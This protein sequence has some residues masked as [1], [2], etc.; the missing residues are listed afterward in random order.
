MS[1]QKEM[2]LATTATVTRVVRI[3]NLKPL[4]KYTPYAL[5]TSHFFHLFHLLPSSPFNTDTLSRSLASQ[6]G[7][8]HRKV[9]P[10]TPCLNQ[11]LSFPPRPPPRETKW[12]MTNARGAVG[13]LVDGKDKSL[14]GEDLPQPL[15][16]LAT[17]RAANK[18]RS[19]DPMQQAR[20]E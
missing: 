13:D 12:R 7:S 4:K 20:P 17:C 16:R 9:V 11:F 8:G 18:D 15:P 19:G 2:P 6:T 5:K 10:V 14:Q 3:K 1:K